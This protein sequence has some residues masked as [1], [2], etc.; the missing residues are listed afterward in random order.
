MGGIGNYGGATGSQSYDAGI[1][2]FGGS[3]AYQAPSYSGGTVDA[4]F[5]AADTNHDGV[6]SRNEFKTAGF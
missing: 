5:N 6:L 3:G 4:V 2:G 1:T